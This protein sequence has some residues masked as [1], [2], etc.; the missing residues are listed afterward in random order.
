MINVT[1]LRKIFADKLL[2]TDNFDDAL[3]K[4]LWIAYQQG[5]DDTK[6]TIN[7]YLI[8]DDWDEA[9]VDTVGSNGNDGLHYDTN[10]PNS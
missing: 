7:S 10:I 8:S 4:S 5:I 6:A 9:R 1:E 3:I 2:A